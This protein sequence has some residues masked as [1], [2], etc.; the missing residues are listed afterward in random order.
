MTVTEHVRG[1]VGVPVIAP[2][3]ALIDRPAGSP[4]ADQLEMVAADELSVAA[5]LQAEGRPGGGLWVPGLVTVTVLVCS[6]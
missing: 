4:V 3:E 1:V 6:R 2:V 5:H